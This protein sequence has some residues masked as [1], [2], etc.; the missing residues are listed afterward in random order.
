MLY[1][2]TSQLPETVRNILPK[3]GQKLFMDIANKQIAKGNNEST[4]IQ[5]SWAYVK[6]KFRKVDGKLVAND[7]DFILPELYE[8]HLES[9][10]N[11][12]IINDEMGELVVDAVLASTKPFKNPNGED[13]FFSEEDLMEIAEQINTQGSTNPTFTHQELSDIIMKYGFNYELV[14][15]ELK[16]NRGLL[17]SIKAV[18]K[19]GKLWIRAM[20]DKR[21]KNHINKFKG[22]SIEA[23]STPV[24]NR[25]TKPQYLGFIFTNNPRD[26]QA[27]VA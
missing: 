22:V 8:L 17:K 10:N 27:L 16:K 21:Y 24:G 23:L 6:S 5:V 25:L 3:N 7:E 14:A 11:E 1:K 19:E 9:T 12:L 4:A 20:L 2:E 26:R 15:N 13:R 18:V